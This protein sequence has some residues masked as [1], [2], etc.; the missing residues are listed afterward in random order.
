MSTYDGVFHVYEELTKK[1][2]HENVWDVFMWM[3]DM[4]GWFFATE[5]RD[6]VDLSQKKKMGEKRK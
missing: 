1:D 4:R 2:E 5:T 3:W 6:D